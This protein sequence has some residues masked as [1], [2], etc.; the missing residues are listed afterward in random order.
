MGSHKIILGSAHDLEKK[1]EKLKVFYRKGLEKVG[2]D[3]YQ[4][5]NLKFEN[6]VVCTKR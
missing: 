4:T 6:Q 2:W 1:F 5:I 3:R